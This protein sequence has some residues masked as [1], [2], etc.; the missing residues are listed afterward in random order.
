MVCSESPRHFFARVLVSECLEQAI[1]AH[2]MSSI[3]RLLALVFDK[4]KRINVFW[5]GTKR[6][7]SEIPW[8]TNCWFINCYVNNL[9]Q[10]G[11]NDRSIFLYLSFTLQ[12]A[13]PQ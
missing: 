2:Y 4:R 5:R 6:K 10:S 7:A 9:E 12:S 1:C 8:L 13:L 3:Q 11:L